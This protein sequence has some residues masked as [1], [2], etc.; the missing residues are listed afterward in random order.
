M[1]WKKLSDY[2]IQSGNYTISKALVKGVAR[3]TLWIGSEPG[4]MLAIRDTSEELKKMAEDKE[5][6]RV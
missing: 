2:A 1:K 6:E 3:F 4:K 5:I